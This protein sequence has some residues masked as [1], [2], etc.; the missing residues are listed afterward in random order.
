MC[1]FVYLHEDFE[2]VSSIQAMHLWC[3]YA[4][5]NGITAELEKKKIAHQEMKQ[6]HVEWTLS[7]V[8]NLHSAVGH[9]AMKTM[10]N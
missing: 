6:L 4:R 8:R 2:N 10:S 7:A 9:K 3:L 1:I 5:S